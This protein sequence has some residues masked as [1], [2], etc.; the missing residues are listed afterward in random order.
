MRGFLEMMLADGLLVSHTTLVFAL[1]LKLN[2]GGLL[3]A[4]NEL[5]I[6]VS[7]KL[8]LESDSKAIISMFTSG[9]SLKNH[10]NSLVRNIYS[11]LLKDRRLILCTPLEKGI[12]VLTGLP[13]KVSI[14]SLVFILGFSS[15]RASLAP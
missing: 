14:L 10:P 8:I 7:G 4:S 2:C 3:H 15:P 9:K 6:V 5:G 13:M 12:V 11:F 1:L